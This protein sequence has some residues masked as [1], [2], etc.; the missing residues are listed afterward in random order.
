MNTLLNGLKT[1][2]YETL[3]VEIFLDK[4]KCEEALPLYLR[5]QYEFYQ[6][7]NMAGAKDVILC[8]DK[9]M[10][11]PAVIEKNVKYLVG[12]TQAE[13]VYLCKAITSYDRKRLIDKKIPFV[14]PGN[15]MYLPFCGL[16]LRGWYAGTQAQSDSFSPSTQ[17][18][19]L[20]LLQKSEGLETNQLNIAN[21]LGYTNMTMVRAFREIEKSGIGENIKIGKEKHLK[22]KGTRRDV[23]QAALPSLHSPVQQTI[24]VRGPNGL[25]AED[26]RFTPAGET[27]LAKVSMLAEPKVPV[28]AIQSRIWKN[29]ELLRLKFEKIPYPESGSIELELWR[30]PVLM[31]GAKETD[32]K[33][34]LYL[35]LKEQRDER[36][37]EALAKM[38]ES[39]L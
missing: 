15:Q 35:S 27:A 22:L 6:V 2:L 25:P 30:Y 12:K 26:A 9:D 4:W 39:V 11:A 3:G 16:D 19:L 38:L 34:S 32:D 29:D 8:V 13:V 20:Y 21:L 5:Q 36:I 33:L 17:Y 18:L 10:Q 1:Y 7:Q 24:Y 23:W 28:W 31:P 37:Q 14:V